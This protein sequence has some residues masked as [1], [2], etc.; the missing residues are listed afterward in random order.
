M[1]KPYNSPKDVFLESSLF[2]KDP[3]EQF[4]HWFEEASSNPQIKEANAMCLATASKSGR[5]SARV[6][7][8]KGF[9]VDG[10]KFFTN[11]ESRKAEDIKE[12]PQVALSFYWEPLVRQ[13]RIEG[14]VEKLSEEESTAYF[15]SRPLENQL[16]AWCSR[17][18][19]PITSRD[20]LEKR[21][22][23]LRQEFPDTQEKLP[24]PP[25]W[26]GY[27]VIPDTFEFWQGQSNR[28]HDRI[29]FRKCSAS[30]LVDGD[31]LHQGEG[32]WVYERLSP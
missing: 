14:I 27:C 25:Y 29:R 10:F 26:G 7:L 13:V 5:P 2:S 15:Q 11:Y 18:G 3:L 9:G 4:K 31:L 1:R 16:G 30:D 21:M 32:D 12:N 20:V 23:E 28:V 22:V 8:L 24:K 19:S 6:V 17:Q